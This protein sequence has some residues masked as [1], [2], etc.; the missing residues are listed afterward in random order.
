MPW[1]VRAIDAETK[2][3]IASFTTM[4]RRPPNFVDR[5]GPSVAQNGEVIAGFFAETFIH[6]RELTIEAPGYETLRFLL[7]PGLGATNTY[8]LRRKSVATPP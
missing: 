5:Y 3:P 1:M 6:E 4:N 8:E 7:M 2:Q